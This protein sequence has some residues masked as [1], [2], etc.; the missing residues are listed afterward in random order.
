MATDPTRDETDS[1]PDDVRDETASLGTPSP[2]RPPRPGKRSKGSGRIPM[3]VPQS[4]VDFEAPFSSEDV[5]FADAAPAVAFDGEGDA[6]FP[7][8][9]ARAKSVPPEE[10]FADLDAD[11]SDRAPNA[12]VTPWRGVPALQPAP[13]E[14]TP[15]RASPVAFTDD[16]RYEDPE[17]TIV[18]KVPESLL[19]LSQG[20]ENTRAFTAPRELIELAKRKREERL[21]G[22]APA[23]A[24]E[25]ATARPARAG[26]AVDD[27]FDALKVPAAPAVP[28]ESFAPPESAAESDS[29]GAPPVA[30]TYSGEMEAVALP[31]R[32]A[33]ESVPA[34]SGPEIEIDP[35]SELSP[36]AQRA[37][38]ASLSREAAP[39]S[40]PVEST[41][42][43]APKRGWY[44]LFG[45]FVL[46]GVVIARWREL[47]LLFH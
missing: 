3:P 47:Q 8:I 25:R 14:V 30:R 2:P 19:E 16:D 29:D 40:A 27:G 26:V 37:V 24:N 33:P 32:T 20:D 5:D 35:S 44:V 22:T 39:P 12:P 38:I 41:A 7:L 46:V 23:P 34:A 18:G 4:R 42:K 13:S 11:L 45:L 28:V 15:P 1:A 10:S 9:T 36:S 43:A 17:P 6:A 31:S 21:A